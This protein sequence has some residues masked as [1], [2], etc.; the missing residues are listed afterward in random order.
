MT[1]KLQLRSQLLVWTAMLGVLAPTSVVGAAEPGR[2]V[3]ARKRGPAVVDAV[4]T[5][6]HGLQGRVYNAQGK[7]L[8]GIDVFVVAPNGE[9]VRTRTNELGD[10]EVNGLKG[11]VYQLA[12]GHGSQMVR[13]WTEGTAPPA[14]EKQVLLVSDPRVLAAQYEPGTFG[15][16]LEEGK[17]MLSNPL[18]VGG[19]IAAAVA[20]PVAIH[21]ADDDDAPSG[22]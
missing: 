5:D 7:P 3:A 13:A 18:V 21:N 11:G 9:H 6:A 10:F 20:I 1:K 4:L 14:A 12:A 16:F 17:L 8:T 19:I 15:H 2:V 22:S